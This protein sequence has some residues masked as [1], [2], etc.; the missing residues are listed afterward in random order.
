MD[1]TLSPGIHDGNP[2]NFPQYTTHIIQFMKKWEK[3]E[4]AVTEKWKK[5]GGI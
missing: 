5:Q 1:E 3:E 4:Y 2:D